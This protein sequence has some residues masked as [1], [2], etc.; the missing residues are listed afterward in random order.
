MPS[1]KPPLRFALAYEELRALGIVLTRLP[2]EYRV[3]LRNGGETTARFVDGL[4]EALELG[5]AMAAEAAA[6]PIASPPRRRR[7][8][9]RGKAKRRHRR[10]WARQG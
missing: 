3:N 9:N 5:R 4:D 6:K 10:K 2:G 7:R 1:E 8:R